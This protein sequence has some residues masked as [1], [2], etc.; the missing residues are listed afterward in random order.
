MADIN[1]AVALLNDMRKVGRVSEPEFQVLSDA[2]KAT[3]ENRIEFPG[4]VTIK[5]ASHRQLK[6]TSLVF[7]H[8]LEHVLVHVDP[9]DLLF[10]VQ[11]TC[12]GFRHAITTVPSLRKTMFLEPDFKATRV[13]RLPFSLLG[14]R[15]GTYG[16]SQDSLKYDKSYHCHIRLSDKKLK[17]WKKHTAIG[18]RLITQPPRSEAQ[19]ELCHEEDDEL[20]TKETTIRSAGA[21]LTVGDILAAVAPMRKEL[22]KELPHHLYREGNWWIDICPYS[23]ENGNWRREEIL[24]HEDL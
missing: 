10:R 18:D 2:V 16:A 17:R 8:L 1:E 21:G 3:S 20:D 15:L 6:V 23:K 19:V 5:T 24:R 14:V 22:T 9:K 4:Q 11:L 7:N 13:T 12:K